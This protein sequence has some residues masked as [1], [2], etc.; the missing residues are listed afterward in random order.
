MTSA[1][2]SVSTFEGQFVPSSRQAWTP[3]IIRLAAETVVAPN[4]EVVTPSAITFPK[5]AFQRMVDEPSQ[6]PMSVSG[7]K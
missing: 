3:P 6:I 4:H 2:V 1:S 5:F 7:V